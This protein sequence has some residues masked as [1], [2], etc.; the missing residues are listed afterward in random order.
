MSDTE[1]NKPGASSALLNIASAYSDSD[2]SQENNEDYK[3]Q[4]SLG[5]LV[6]NL[7]AEA[8]KSAAEVTTSESQNRAA[9]PVEQEKVQSVTKIVRLDS[10]KV[11]KISTSPS[12]KTS[13]IR[14][15]E[16]HSKAPADHVRAADSEMGDERLLNR[17]PVNAVSN[18]TTSTNFV[19]EG[20]VVQVAQDSTPV[21]TSVV[22]DKSKVKDESD[23]ELSSVTD[24]KLVQ[25]D[26]ESLLPQDKMGGMNSKKEARAEVEEIVIDSVSPEVIAEEVTETKSPV[27]IEIDDNSSQN[28]ERSVKVLETTIAGECNDKTRDTANNIEIVHDVTLVEDTPKEQTSKYELKTE[29]NILNAYLKSKL[30]K[31]VISDAHRIDGEVRRFTTDVKNHDTVRNQDGN[32]QGS[33]YHRSSVEI[34]ATAGSVADTDPDI[35]IEKEITHRK[36]TENVSD[37]FKP[38]L[39]DI[40]PRPE[41]KPLPKL[42]RIRMNSPGVEAVGKKTDSELQASSPALYKMLESCEAYQSTPSSDVKKP[43]PGPI[44]L[45]RNFSCLSTAV[46]DPEKKFC[47]E[48]SD[49]A[50]S[51]P[52]EAPVSPSKPEVVPLQDK[53]PSRMQLASPSRSLL[54]PTFQQSSP[55]Q[56]TFQASFSNM[57]NSPQSQVPTFQPLRKS[58][59]PVAPQ[60]QQRVST[61]RE[62]QKRT[63]PLI[64]RKADISSAK[65]K[66][67][68]IEDSSAVV[69]LKKVEVSSPKVTSELDTSIETISS[70][71]FYHHPSLIKEL[72]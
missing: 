27:V 35:I 15:E 48:P 28:S 17:K 70:G 30:E 62:E 52:S 68:K 11:V 20:S 43:G 29:S 69:L 19:A 47:P 49:S 10:G 63:L 42:D 3:P 7:R 21:L 34:S 24:N 46:A 37:S 33:D 39:L 57:I 56:P 59:Q 54:S 26:S 8:K 4:K 5:S 64:L 72:Y 2:S 23:S 16:F 55:T 66:E 41:L 50:C 58:P 38:N 65:A 12:S 1:E 18:L 32:F 13:E 67:P 22:T 53:S 51:L 9:H 36:A 45:K 31:K 40:K 60:Q 14:N 25:G 61:R 71:T 6:E 44:K